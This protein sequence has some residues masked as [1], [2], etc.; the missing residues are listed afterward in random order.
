MNQ[1]NVYLI[2]IDYVRKQ[3]AHAYRHVSMALTAHVMIPVSGLF[4][5]ILQLQRV[6]EDPTVTCKSWF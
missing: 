1:R 5:L 2:N 3:A 4:D 6:L